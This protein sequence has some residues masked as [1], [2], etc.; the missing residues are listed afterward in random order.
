[1]N[2]RPGYEIG[3]DEAFTGPRPRLDPEPAAPDFS[4]VPDLPP[5][6]PPTGAPA[7]GPAPE[8]ATVAAPVTLAPPSQPMPV[9]AQPAP[10]I[11]QAAPMTQPVV[12]PTST[13]PQTAP[14]P[15]SSLPTMPPPSVAAPAQAAASSSGF[16]SELPAG[17]DPE[18]L[19]ALDAVTR[20]GAS[21]LHI[22]AD[23]PPMI[24]VNGALEP[25]GPEWSRERAT[26]AL[27][28]LLDQDKRDVF[29]RTLELDWSFALTERDRFRA[30]YY[31]QRG[32]IGAAFRLI[33]VD[34]RPLNALGLPSSV[35]RFAAL[36]RGLVLVAGPTGSGKSTTLAALIDL[37]NSTRTDHIMTVEDPIEF[38]HTN[39]SSLINQ[40]EVGEDTKSF[41]AA[42]KHVLRQDP[43]VILIGELRDLETIEVA[44]TAAETGHLVFATLHTQSAPQ[45]IDRV[46][47]VF[48][49]HQQEQIR[50]QLAGTLQGVVCQ[51][52]V[53]TA[54]GRGRV[55]AAEVMISTPAISNLIREAKIHQIPTA[56]QV[57]GD[58]GMQTLDQ[59]LAALVNAGTVTRETAEEK[60]QDKEVFARLVQGGRS[61]TGTVDRGAR[62][63]DYGTYGQFPGGR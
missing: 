49:P 23:G 47:G 20:R 34:I 62:L 10:T 61:S 30:N 3:I 55:V 11:P 15:S 53:K 5:M 32:A 45:T 33:P 60:A 19:R 24:R 38:V 22:S 58:H 42:L 50:A 35:D 51:T 39:K 9:V 63:D 6:A 25:L 54:D 36:A 46:I 28:S 44:L 1:M 41:A 31:R 2:E 8:L 27:L 17:A 12:Q 43:D 7:P 18:L 56:M 59:H 21:D 16:G 13:P 48:P 29:E 57:A 26:T 52:L 40:R 37:V 4:V 14:I